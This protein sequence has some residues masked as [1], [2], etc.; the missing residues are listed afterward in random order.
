MGKGF[1]VKVF[2]NKSKG[3]RGYPT[4]I[5]KSNKRKVFDFI[6]LY[7]YNSYSPID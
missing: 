3:R 2:V 4:I 1:K 6:Y 7:A 5:I